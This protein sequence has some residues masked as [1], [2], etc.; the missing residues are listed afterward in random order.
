[1]GRSSVFSI[2]YA[3]YSVPHRTSYWTAHS[4][5]LHSGLSYVVKFLYYDAMVHY[6][7]SSR[8]VEEFCTGDHASLVIIFI[9]LGHVQQ[10]AGA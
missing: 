2:F 5:T 6:V 4:V 8:Y 9:V 7:V 1:M 10:L 3:H